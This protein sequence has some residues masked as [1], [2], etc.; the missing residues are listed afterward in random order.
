MGNRLNPRPDSCKYPENRRGTRTHRKYLQSCGIG[1]LDGTS[2][3]SAMATSRQ[4]T[5]A[6][7]LMERG[8]DPRAV[9]GR[10]IRAIM[11]DMADYFHDVPSW[12]WSS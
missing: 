6:L 2:M 5:K 10:V 4:H 9:Q 12:A 8:I 1:R 3:V 7:R 11:R